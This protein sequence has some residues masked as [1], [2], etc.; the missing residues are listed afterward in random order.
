MKSVVKKMSGRKKQWFVEK[1]KII[2][3]LYSSTEHEQGEDHDSDS[4]REGE[5][6]N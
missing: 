3:S 1:S 4:F 5:E 2:D 6:V